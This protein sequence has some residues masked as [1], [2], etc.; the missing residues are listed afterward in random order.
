MKNL[1][2]CIILLMIA[3]PDHLR[4]KKAIIPAP[5]TPVKN[6]FII[7]IDGFRWQEIF[8]GADSTL[9]NDEQYTSDTATMRSLYWASSPGERRKRLM[10][11][12]WNVLSAKGQ[13]FGN[14]NFNNKVNV[15]NAY[16]ISYPGYNEIFTGTTDPAVS[17]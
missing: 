4:E 5:S 17:S 12:F 10:P 11:F 14:R 1:W 6:L 3:R 2:P 9:L 8:N 7:T 15:A 16:A 13:V